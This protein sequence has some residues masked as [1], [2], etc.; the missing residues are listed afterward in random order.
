LKLKRLIV[1]LVL[2]LGLAVPVA[3]TAETGGPDQARLE[4]NVAKIQG[5]VDVYFAVLNRTGRLTARQE[6]ALARNLDTLARNQRALAAYVATYVEPVKALVLDPAPLPNNALPPDA[7]YGC[8]EGFS[9]ADFVARF[10]FSVQVAFD[11]VATGI[12]RPDIER[13]QRLIASSGGAFDQTAANFAAQ[14]DIVRQGAAIDYFAGRIPFSQFSGHF[15]GW[16]PLLG[17]NVGL[18]AIHDLGGS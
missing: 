6:V 3:A 17:C 10:G 16:Y 12:L 1:A 4:A 9:A 2:A 5:Y 13:W 14:G 11:R 8:P 15:G 18:A 7:T